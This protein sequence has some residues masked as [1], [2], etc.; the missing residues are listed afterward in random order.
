MKD[1]SRTCGCHSH[2]GFQLSPEGL[3]QRSDAVLEG[4]DMGTAH[5]YID[6]VVS[7]SG[8]RR[9]EMT[10]IFDEGVID[11]QHRRFVEGSSSGGG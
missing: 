11:E 1:L 7:V 8:S 9:D 10:M 3:A 6:K 4:V 2:N 5:G